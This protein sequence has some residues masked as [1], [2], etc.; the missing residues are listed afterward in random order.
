MLVRRSSGKKNW[1][2]TKGPLNKEKRLWGVGWKSESG[3]RI[4]FVGKKLKALQEKQRDEAIYGS[5]EE[6]FWKREDAVLCNP[7]FNA[8]KKYLENT[9]IKFQDFGGLI[10]INY[11][12]LTT[13]TRIHLDKSTCSVHLLSHVQLCNPMN[14]STPGFPVRHQLSELAQTHVCLVGLEKYVQLATYLINLLHIC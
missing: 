4:E 14:R 1:T 9:H 7:I 10:F 5:G 2:E 12:C 8:L 11:G 6:Q 3:L 13:L